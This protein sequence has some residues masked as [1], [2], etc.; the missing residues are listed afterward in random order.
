MTLFYYCEHEI[1]VPK[2]GVIPSFTLHLC[3]E[4]INFETIRFWLHI[5]INQKTELPKLNA[6]NLN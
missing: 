2:K 3:F 1:T 5:K 6:K 4:P